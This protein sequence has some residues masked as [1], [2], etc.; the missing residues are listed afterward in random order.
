[1]VNSMDGDAVAPNRRLEGRLFK[2]RPSFPVLARWFLKTAMWLVFLEWVI[3]IF[4]YPS[5]SLV[6]TF[7][8][9]FYATDTSFYGLV[10]SFLWMFGAHVL[11]LAILAAI[12]VMAFP[13][14]YQ[15]TKK[16]RFFRFRLSTFPALVSGPFGVVSA[17][18]L[19]G[20][21]IFAAFIV[22]AC[23]GYTI[24]NRRN[25]LTLPVSSRERRHLF[26]EYAGYRLG[27][28]GMFVIGFLFVPI[29]RGS[30]LLR[31]IG[32]P[33]EHAARYHIWLG[34]LT[35]AIFTLHS[36]CYMG[37]WGLRGNL[38][39]KLLKWNKH[40]VSYFPGLV[41]LVAGLLM[42]VTTLNPVRRRN[43]ELF[44][45]THQLYAVFVIFFALHVG[46]F[47]FSVSAG[48]I[49]LFLLDR[50]LRF[51][52]SRTTVDVISAT[53]L[54]CGA[55]EL[56]LSKPRNL[57]YNALSFIFLK[58]KEISHLQWHPF[59]VSSSPLDGKNHLSVVI[60]GLGQWTKKLSDNI[61]NAPE[62]IQEGI[63][64][65]PCSTITAS[66]EGPYGHQSP[67]HLKYENLVFVG[68]G[69]GITPFLAILSDILHR[70]KEKKPCLPKQILL[71]W[72]VKRSQELSLLSLVDAESICPSFP[73]NLHLQIQTYVTQEPGPQLEDGSL[74][75]SMHRSTFHNANGKSM[76]GLV[77][78]G[79]NMW[80]GVYTI[81][82]IV[83]FITLLTLLKAFYIKPY[84]ITTWWVQGLLFLICMAV[85]VAVFGGVVIFLW[86]RWERKV[87]G[88]DKCTN[89]NDK[90][91]SSQHS[92]PKSQTKT[93]QTSLHHLMST[94]YGRRPNMQAIFNSVSNRWGNVDVGVIVCGPPDLN[95]NVA[96]EC[97]SR[98][99]WGRWNQPIFHFNSHSFE[100]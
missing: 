2:W 36:L 100:L 57:Q 28:V 12:Y 47:L 72:A 8:K 38:S 41:S 1:M 43:F 89:G 29:S 16:S 75:I 9:W 73:D 67:Y 39:H 27:T 51:W 55:V 59:S 62:K 83:G 3:M 79:N 25:T 4:L 10:A 71:V 21:L 85:S 44:F 24:Q 86:R 87:S 91:V 45:Y 37:S 78:T 20:I 93:C 13:T 77:A 23:Y 52:Q 63:P 54:P 84:N 69:I 96:A 82:P 19:I 61:S 68:G 50:F 98:N 18:E 53:N 60:K 48:A 26:I 31:V 76:S 40:D 11:I 30:V 65:Q 7:L 14:E 42:W 46:D 81:V 22:W 97:R 95:S 99:I 80:S 90:S 34:H 32:V 5:P 94:Q 15:K 17:A 49:F 92:D 58:L 64:F 66:V 88:Y 33:F 74:Q 70:I 35:M 56:I 6:G